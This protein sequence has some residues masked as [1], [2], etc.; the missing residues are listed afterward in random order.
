MSDQIER[1][2]RAIYEATPTKMGLGKNDPLLPWSQIGC[3]DGLKSQLMAQARA[4]I[5]AASEWQ[6]ISTAKKNGEPILAVFHNDIF[7]RIEPN[8]PDLEKLHGLRIS[9]RHP[10]ICD[11]GMD[12]GWNIAAPVGYG[13]LP[14]E[15]IAAWQPLPQPPKVTT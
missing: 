8:R 12:L 2:A 13:G 4:A 7:P 5:A 10:G 3:L 9:L 6:D 15:W 14:D 1:V 11:D